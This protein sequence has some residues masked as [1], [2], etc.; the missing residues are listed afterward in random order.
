MTV[1]NSQ[2]S[3]IWVGNGSTQEFYYSFLIPFAGQCQLV[4]TPVGGAPQV[5]AP[6]LYSV[7]NVG[8]STGGSVVYPI[9][10]SPIPTGATLTFSRV[11][12][13]QQTFHPS[14]Q[15]PIYN[16]VL[17]A[18]LD[19]LDMQIMQ[20]EQQL[21]DVSINGTVV[22]EISFTGSVSVAFSGT[23]LPG[24]GTTSALITLPPG[25][26]GPIGFTPTISVG[27]TG[28]PTGDAPTVS[29]S[30]TALD[31]VIDFGIP[32]GATGATGPVG[33]V[34][35][36]SIGTITPGAAGSPAEATITGAAPAQVLSLTIPQGIAGTVDGVAAAAASAAAA[37]TDA[38]NAANSATAAANSASTATTEATDAANSATAA[39]NSASTIPAPS[40]AGSFLQVNPGAT[41]Y[42][43]QTPA[44]VLADIGAQAAGSYA[45]LDNANTWPLTQS[46]TIQV[47]AFSAAVTL[48]LTQGNDV[49][50]TLTGNATLANPSAMMPGCSGH[51]ALTQDA[52]G[53]R[54]LAY[55]SYWKFGTNGTP[56]LSTAANAEDVLVYWVRDATHIIASL[57]QG[58]Q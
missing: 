25:P 31:P 51:V 45:G 27:A 36:L 43:I 23:E 44:Q 54:T 55:G 21:G 42:Q 6:G 28:L 49:A 46:A 50:L 34:N 52:T 33:A 2:T 26:Q 11:V 15:G 18:A 17:E 56:T 32:A 37:A 8:N 30:G 10:G 13:Y 7:S 24:I 41:A 39:A 53:G 5:I 40:A 4:F 58:V 9:S 3:V 38:T 12:P 16:P 22:N 19:A 29:L 20:V 1:T 35:T 57:V 48:D 47:A 14:A